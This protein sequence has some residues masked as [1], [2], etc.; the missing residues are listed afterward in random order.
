MRRRSSRS[1]AGRPM[2]GSMPKLVRPADQPAVIDAAVSVFG[3][4]GKLA[5]L[6]YLNHHGPALRADI[7]DATEIATPTL[8][9]HLAELEHAGAVTADLPTDQRRG[10]SI[11]YATDPSR[12]RQ[13]LTVMGSYVFNDDEALGA[14]Q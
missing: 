4:R 10:R 5:I 1:T 11:R 8:G 6:R 2:L 3:N 7:T 14:A 13:L 12:L 9:S